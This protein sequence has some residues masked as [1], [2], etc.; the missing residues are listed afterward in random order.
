MQAIEP[1]SIDSPD[2]RVLGYRFLS[3][4]IW[5]FIDKSWLVID[6]SDYT[7]GVAR[8]FVGEG[9]TAPTPMMPKVELEPE[10][11]T[12]NMIKM[13]CTGSFQF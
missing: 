7:D 11:Q 13:Q 4:F 3:F 6:Q 10:D 8:K 2:G 12:L 9:P 1:V 5:Y